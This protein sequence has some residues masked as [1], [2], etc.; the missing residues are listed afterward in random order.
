MC[1]SSCCTISSTE[2][3]E[4]EFILQQSFEQIYLA[5]YG[6]NYPHTKHS[7]DRCIKHNDQQCLVVYQQVIEG[8]NKIESM[9]DNNTLETTLN[10]IERTCTSNNEHIANFVCYGGIMSLFFY[11]SA[12][13]DEKILSRIREFPERIRK[14]I[15]NSEFYWFYNRPDKS[16][17]INYI[18]ALEIDWEDKRQKQFIL[19]LFE[20][21]ITDID[22][23]PWVL[24]Q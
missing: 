10:I 8:R 5:K 22:G 21:S 9:S 2:Q 3:H 11:D 12:E 13:E 19:E 16:I 7:L 14:L 6:L 20:K 1:I 15:F 24:R 4:Q 18:S 17:W 23:E